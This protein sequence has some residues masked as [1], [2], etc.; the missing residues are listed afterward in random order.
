LR[1]YLIIAVAILAGLLVL[2]L[3]TRMAG[4]HIRGEAI[5]PY[6]YVIAGAVSI[7]VLLAGGLL[8]E[9]GSGAP[10]MS[11]QPAYIEGGQIK[12]GKFKEN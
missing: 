7:A 12:P 11:Y 9:T 8:L 6:R 10:E 2:A 3:L 5:T 1:K 4:R